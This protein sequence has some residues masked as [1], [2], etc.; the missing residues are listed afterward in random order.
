VK[1]ID[2]QEEG[3]MEMVAH[4]VYSEEVKTALDKWEKRADKAVG[5]FKM[6][7]EFVASEDSI[8]DLGLAIDCWNPLWHDGSYAGNTRWGGIIA[9]PMY[10]ERLKQG[11]ETGLIMPLSLGTTRHLYLG[12]DWEFFQPV[13]PNDSFRVWRNR[14]QLVD[15]TSPD[16]KEQHFR[17]VQQDLDFIN[18]KDELVNKFKLHV[19]IFVLPEGSEAAVEPIVDYQYA[20]E[21]L[22]IIDGIANE[23]K[24]R[25]ADIL[26]W[27]DV[28][29]GDE[30]GKV[31]LGPTTLWDQLILFAVRNEDPLIPMREL[32]KRLGRFGLLMVDP[33]TNVSHMP[34]EWHFSDKAAS[35]SGEPHAFHFGAQARTLMARLI[36]NWMGD[37]GFLKRFNWRHMMRTPIGDTVF[38]RGKVTNKRNDNGGEP[39]VDLSVWQENIRGYVTEAAVATVRLLSKESPG[40]RK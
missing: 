19:E 29:V 31:I 37:D 2:R 25:G 30:L 3:F 7:H 10:L 4:G 11:T 23:E 1:K 28:N 32:R 38:G 8:R 9:P 20:R 12:E 14:P 26:Y 15:V 33:V 17:V 34:I 35:M 6:P 5:W 27:E 36:T 39:L 40:K 22:E 18:Q 24:V 13:R 21:E 16:S